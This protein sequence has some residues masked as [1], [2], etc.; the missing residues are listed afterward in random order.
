MALSGTDSTYNQFVIMADHLV[1][2]KVMDPRELSPMG[3]GTINEWAF[4]QILNKVANMMLEHPDPLLKIK[5][6]LMWMKAD[7]KFHTDIYK[8]SIIPLDEFKVNVL[9]PTNPYAKEIFQAYNP[10]GIHTSNILEMMYHAN[11][12]KEVIHH[13]VNQLRLPFDD[14]LEF[15][16]L[17]L[18]HPH[19]LITPSSP[20]MGYSLENGITLSMLFLYRLID[21]KTFLL[22]D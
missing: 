6:G 8:V 17:T 9:R 1:N 10:N 21:F 16:R 14:A 19:Q 3:P 7:L 5:Y 13:L 20:G 22:N 12:Y 11:S 2:I 15:V 18:F 4:I